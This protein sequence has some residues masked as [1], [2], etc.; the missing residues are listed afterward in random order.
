MSNLS[1]DDFCAKSEKLVASTNKLANRI[2]LMSL[3]PPVA[4]KDLF[5]LNFPGVLAA[6]ISCAETVEKSP[7]D[8]AVIPDFGNVR[9]KITQRL[10]SKWLIFN[11]VQGFI[12]GIQRPTHLGTTIVAVSSNRLKSLHFF[13]KGRYLRYGRRR[14]TYRRVGNGIG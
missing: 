11:G 10:W 1:D 12:A 5:E 14:S 13:G 9:V 7:I 2:F 6:T 3:V 8:H 4:N